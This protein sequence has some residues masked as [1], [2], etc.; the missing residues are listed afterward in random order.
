MRRKID[1]YLKQW[2]LMQG[3]KPLVIGGARQVGKTYS[4]REY[5]RQ[6]GSFIEINF[7]TNPEFKR[8]FDTGF[9]THEIIKQIS[10]LLPMAKFLNGDTL[11]FFDEMQECPDCATSLKFFHEDGRYDV[12]CS[13]SLMG[14][15]YKEITS[16]SVGYKTDVFMHS[17]DFEEFL[18]A[19]GYAENISE[20]IYSHIVDC[21]PFSALELDRLE[22]LFTDYII[23]GGM[24]EVVSHFIKEGNFSGVLEKQRQ[25]IVDYEQDIVKYAS[26]ID[27]ARIRNVYRHVPIFLSKEN[28]KFQVTKIER[29]ARSREYAGCVDWLRDA[30]IVNICYCLHTLEPPLKGNYDPT[31]YKL[32]YHDSGMLVA[33]LD[34]ESSATLRHNRDFGVYKGAL[35]ENVVSESLSK[36]SLPLYYY[37]KENSQ[38]EMDFFLRDGE[39][40]VPVEVK[41]KSGASP[42]LNSL[43]SGK[44]YPHIHYGIKLSAQNVGFANSIYTIPYYCSFLLSRWLKE[45]K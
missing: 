37:K 32:Y 1:N 5:G 27:K 22:R 24:P 38:L 21:H 13:G 7:I 9:S 41:A 23:T 43:V 16:N 35:Y 2:R 18:W 44:A 3:H 4:V 42:S 29:N 19:L 28:K 17:L 11:I 40:V 14:L 30:G 26:G 34:E 25:L 45:H 12:I 31:K 39:S 20:N 6:Y 36:Q 15:N 10:L 8:I 33:S